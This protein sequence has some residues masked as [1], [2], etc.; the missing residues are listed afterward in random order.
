MFFR[1]QVWPLLFQQ[2]PDVLNQKTLIN[3]VSHP[4]L[5]VVAPG[6]GSPYL[7][8][9][10]PAVEL[11]LPWD[12]NNADIKGRWHL[13]DEQSFLLFNRH[14]KASQQQLAEKLPGE[15][16]VAETA[17]GQWQRNF[18]V[19]IVTGCCGAAIDSQHIYS[20]F[21]VIQA[22]VTAKTTDAQRNQPGQQLFT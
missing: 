20:E 18:V 11:W 6:F 12:Y 14:H 16:N 7:R 19:V 13:S 21:I 5:G 9:E 3:G 8:S 4:M 2:W 15:A 10:L 17:G 1:C 22:D